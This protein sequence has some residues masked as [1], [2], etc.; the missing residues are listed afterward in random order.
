MN[1]NP[2]YNDHTLSEP[3]YDHARLIFTISLAVWLLALKWSRYLD[4][5]KSLH[6]YHR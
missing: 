1:P 3:K 6:P 4:E 2:S 5:A